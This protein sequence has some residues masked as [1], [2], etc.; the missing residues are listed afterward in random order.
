MAGI[1]MTAMT[2]CTWAGPKVT[3]CMGLGPDARPLIVA[4]KLASKIFAD[5]GV[6]TEWAE[7]LHPTNSCQVNAAVVITLSYDTSPKDDPRA[8]AYARPYERKHIV[9]F[10]DRVQQKVPPARAPVLLAYILV[11]EITHILQ[12]INRHSKSG[13]M[14]AEWDAD[15]FFKMWSGR[16]LGFTELDVELIH[17][18]LEGRLAAAP[19]AAATNSEK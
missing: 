13:V 4:E 3:V 2:A 1:A 15:D 8:W 17:L 16:P 9:V 19:G 5:I 6:E 12:G 18:G 10:W 14:K 7:R 11:H